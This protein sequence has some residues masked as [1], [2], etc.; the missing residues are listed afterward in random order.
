M[1]EEV[2]LPFK[3]Y[4]WSLQGGHVLGGH[5]AADDTPEWI[6]AR[7][8]TALGMKSRDWE[9]IQRNEQMHKEAFREAEALS[10]QLSNR[11][12]VNVIAAPSS[13]LFQFPSCNSLLDLEPEV[14]Q[15]QWRKRGRECQPG[16]HDGH[17]IHTFGLLIVLVLLCA[18]KAYSPEVKA[19]AVRMPPELVRQALSEVPASRVSSGRLSFNMYG[20]DGRYHNLTLEFSDSGL[21]TNFP[22]LLEKH[23][24]AASSW[25][26]LANHGWHGYSL[27]S[28]VELASIWD[29]FAWTCFI[30]TNR[31]KTHRAWEDVGAFLFPRLVFMCGSLVDARCL[32]K[33]S[34]APQPLPIL[35]TADGN[36]RKLPRVNKLLLLRRVK[37]QRR[38]RSETMRTHTDLVSGGNN[39]VKREAA[40]EVCCY[41]QKLVSA[42]ADCRQVMVAWDA[43]QYDCDTLIGCVYCWRTGAAGFLP[44]QNLAPVLTEELDEELQTLL[45]QAKITRV[46]SFQTMRA[47]SHMMQAIGLPLSVFEKPSGLHLGPFAVEEERVKLDGCFWVVNVKTNEVQMQIPPNIQ[48]SKIPI[49]TSVSDMG[50]CN[51][52]SLDMLQY[53]HGMMVNP[54]YDPY[55]RV[56]NDLK[57]SLKFSGLFRTVLEYAMFYNVG[58]GPSGTKAWHQKRAAH[59]KEFVRLHTAFEEP[60]LSFAPHIAAEMKLPEPSSKEEL[61]HLFN[62]ILSM[63]SLTV[64]GPLTKLMRWFSFWECS[65]FFSGQCFMLKMIMARGGAPENLDLRSGI[66]SCCRFLS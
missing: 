16:E 43:S 12:Y 10:Q 24:G 21:T 13:C 25:R 30:K 37:S 65:E 32:Q 22:L 19:A 47:L 26:Q 11:S 51:L 2:P 60:F 40:T 58:Y 44:I 49:F 39:I 66:V 48:L 54:L 55:H 9:F 46:D 36:T 15:D 17:G 29:I 34:Q 8:S 57:G 52:P 33:A 42:F 14:P 53:R 23:R 20:T 59:A 18:A 1:D 28:S 64:L 62:K 4:Q 3:S 50:P 38:H 35:R 6:W 56:W 7:V 27:S 61:E 5:I 45:Y 41:M 31:A 63:P